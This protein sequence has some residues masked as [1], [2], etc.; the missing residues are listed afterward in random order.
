MSKDLPPLLTGGSRR[1]IGRRA[2]SRLGPAR[3]GPRFSRALL[4]VPIV[5]VVALFAIIVG[6]AGGGDPAKRGADVRPESLAKGVKPPQALGQAAA[7]GGESSRFAVNLTGG[8]L[9][10]LRFSHR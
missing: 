7:G 6:S 3:E 9:V 10:R 4:L 2:P 1:R 5:G 8:D